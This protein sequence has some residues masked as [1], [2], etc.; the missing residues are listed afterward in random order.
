MVINAMA[1]SRTAPTITASRWLSF[2]G[3]PG[4]PDLPIS[5]FGGLAEGFPPRHFRVQLTLNAFEF[6]FCFDCHERTV[7]AKRSDHIP[8]SGDIQLVYPTQSG[9]VVMGAFEGS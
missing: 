1:A 5:P 7:R 3:R 6:L 9:D 2:E 8:Q 4:A